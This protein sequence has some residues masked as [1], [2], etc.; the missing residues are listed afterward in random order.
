M[1]ATS[2][3]QRK[4]LKSGKIKSK[5]ENPKRIQSHLNPT[6]KQKQES[7]IHKKVFKL[8]KSKHGFKSELRKNSNEKLRE[9]S[10]KAP[11]SGTLRNYIKSRIK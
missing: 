11:K 2:K 7:K 10:K 1:A 4:L 8:T 3:P 5:T 9:L 6:A